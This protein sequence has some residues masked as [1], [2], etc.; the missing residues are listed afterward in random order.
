MARRNIFNN[1]LI[2]IR[3]YFS[4]FREPSITGSR[5]PFEIMIF[6]KRKI[7]KY[8]IG[9]DITDSSGKNCFAKILLQCIC[10]RKI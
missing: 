6:L 8:K 9:N 10:M 3:Q 1:V 2:V 7:T 5:N 4:N